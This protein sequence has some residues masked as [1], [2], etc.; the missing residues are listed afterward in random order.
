MVPYDEEKGAIQEFWTLGCA[1][2]GHNVPLSPDRR[3]QS[4]C[5][6]GET[7]SQERQGQGRRWVESSLHLKIVW[8]D[9]LAVEDESLLDRESGYFALLGEFTHTL[10]CLQCPSRNVE[11]GSLALCARSLD[12]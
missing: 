11:R 12:M 5:R 7:M 1:K 2:S 9:L 8:F 10:H 6:T 4:S 3:S